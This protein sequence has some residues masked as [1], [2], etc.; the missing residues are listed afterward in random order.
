VHATMIRHVLRSPTSFFDSTPVGRIVNRYYCICRFV[1]FSCWIFS[2]YYC[3]FSKLLVTIFIVL[4]LSVE[5]PCF[6]GSI[7]YFHFLI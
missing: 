7:I 4:F 3:L 6:F 5:S 1:C 2:G